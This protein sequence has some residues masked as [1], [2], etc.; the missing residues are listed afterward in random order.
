[1][2]GKRA[3]GFIVSPR[4][5]TVFFIAAPLLGLALFRVLP[6]VPWIR[7][8][9]HGDGVN[10]T[11]LGI[12]IGIWTYAHL[13]A[14]LFRS[15]ANPQTFRQHRA[16]FVAVPLVLVASL[17]LSDWVL[18]FAIALEWLWDVYHSSMQVFGFCRIY[19]A[20]AG[21]RA[22]VGRTLD[23]WLNLLLYV[24][25]IICGLSFHAT[26]EGAS[27]AFKRVGWNGP[28]EAAAHIGGLQ[29]WLGA[30]VLIG[31]TAF[32]AYYVTS[33]VRLARAGAYRWSPQKVALLASTGLTSILVWGFMPPLQAFFVAN[34]FHGLQ[35][36][37]IVWALEKK[38][39]GNLFRV[40]GKAGGRL[41]ALLLFLFCVFGFGVS[42]KLFGDPDEGIRWVLCVG[43]TCALMHFWYDGFV[44]SV[45]KREVC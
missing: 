41:A 18:C 43:V 8:W 12:L 38:S 36:F 34:F 7:A 3:S 24:G 42:R 23:V 45:S 29:I 11:G 10:D 25:P 5:D 28:S 15:H 4:Y 32:F 19:D 35:Y 31:G 27:G 44:W 14:V 20:R 26:L 6:G 33:F 40:E 13:V 21:N 37:A 16:R 30:A 1:M 39:I 17:L 2:G 9:H 22:A